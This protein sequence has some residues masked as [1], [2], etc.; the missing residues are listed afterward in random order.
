MGNILLIHVLNNIELL[1]C[2]L[3]LITILKNVIFGPLVVLS[4]I[5][6]KIKHSFIVNLILIWKFLEEYLD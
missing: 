4:H 6:S 2:S 1:N 3:K 5:F